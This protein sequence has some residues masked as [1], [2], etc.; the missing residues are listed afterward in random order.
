MIDISTLSRETCCAWNDFF[1]A[2]GYEVEFN[3]WLS[4]HEA[5]YCFFMLKAAP[6]TTKLFPKGKSA[7]LQV[8][9]DFIN[10]ASRLELLDIAKL[11]TLA[12]IQP[13]L[14]KEFFEPWKNQIEKK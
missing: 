1:Y 6:D 13:E 8:F 2:L 9:E 11:D 3:N 7:T 5:G 14:L 4:F 10:S 12:P